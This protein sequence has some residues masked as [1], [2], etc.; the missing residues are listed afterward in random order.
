[1]PIDRRIGFL[2]CVA[3]LAAS[4]GCGRTNPGY[5][6]LPV[7]GVVTL[8]GEPLAGAEVMF[9]SADA[10]RGFGL[11]DEEG[12]FSVTTR[13]YGP[14]LPAGTYRVF[15]SGSGTTRLGRSGKPV[16]LASAYQESG[17][18]QVTVTADGEPLSFDLRRQPAGAGRGTAVDDGSGA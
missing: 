16:R 6:M 4:V 11:T 12:R 8:E 3:L 5:T 14:G 15:V 1:V 9:D 18:G 10:P 13:Q 2:V 7:A 17:L